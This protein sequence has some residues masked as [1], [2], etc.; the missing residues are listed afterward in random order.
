MEESTMNVRGAWLATGLAVSMCGMLVAADPPAGWT[1]GTPREELRPA[2]SY[3]PTG[4][5][6]GRECFVIA[7]DQRDGLS[8]WWTKTFDVEGG[9]TYRFTAWRKGDGVESLRRS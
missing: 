3:Q 7:G 6:G 4:G 2:F 8:G 9:K 5:R 1:T